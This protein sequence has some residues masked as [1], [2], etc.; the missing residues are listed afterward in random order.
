ML[1]STE[2]EP[3]TE[4]EHHNEPCPVCKCKMIIRHGVGIDMIECKDHPD[5]HPSYMRWRF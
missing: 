1:L 4:P 5:D 2:P 3:I